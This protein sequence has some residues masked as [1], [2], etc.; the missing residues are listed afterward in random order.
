MKQF[1]KI[2]VT[3]GLTVALSAA[4]AVPTAAYHE[5]N[6]LQLKFNTF[7]IHGNYAK[8]Y[9][10]GQANLTSKAGNSVAVAVFW[11]AGKNLSIL[12]RHPGVAKVKGR[13]KVVFKFPDGK[14]IVFPMQK[15]GDQLQVRVG[16]G[17]RGTGFYDALMAN[18]RVLVEMPSLGDAIDVD[19]SEREEAA[20]GA[21]YCREWLHA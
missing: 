1:R 2:A 10:S 4:Q 6:T 21:L 5:G 8:R 15:A 9:C 16:F 3:I 13:Q 19:L 20:S 12:A 17:P 7:T 14:R 18:R 11:R